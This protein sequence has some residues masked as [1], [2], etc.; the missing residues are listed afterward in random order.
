MALLSPKL[1]NGKKFWS[2]QTIRD[3]D[4][5]VGPVH[6]YGWL[7]RAMQEHGY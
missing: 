3:P 7:N 5:V 6:R 4:E 2:F 1:W